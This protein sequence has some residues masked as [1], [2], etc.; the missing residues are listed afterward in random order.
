MSDF[1]YSVQPYAQML[2]Q[3]NQL[4][5]SAAELRYEETQS[6]AAMTEILREAG[7]QVQ[8]GVAGIPTAYR[9]TY[10]TG[11]PVIGL[12]A[13]Y[14]A[15][16]GISQQ[17]D[18]AEYRPRPETTHG[19][20]CGHNLLGVGVIGAALALKDYL[21]DHPNAG[22][23][24]VLGCPAE[25]GGSGKT[26]MAR[27]GVFNDLDI[28]L[29]WH[30]ATINAAMT[31][32]LLANCQ[33]YFSFHGKASHAAA[34]PQKGRSALDA[35]ELMNVGVNY[36]REHMEMTDRVHYAVTNT[37]G[38]S[39]NVVQS[40]AQVL[41]LIRSL[42]NESVKALYERV[43]DIAR[44]A[45]LMTGTSLD[46]T[47]D[48]ACSN[49]VPND[50]LGQ[51]M[52]D[53]MLKVGLPAYTT[54]EGEYIQRFR[55]VIGDE[56]ADN[57]LG[58]LPAFDLD[59]RRSLCQKHPMGDFI[60]PFEPKD[61]VVTA[62]SD[63]GDVSQIVPLIQLQ[64]ACFCLGTPPH[65]WVLAAQGTSSYA[66]KGTLFAA[67]VIA[68]ATATLMESPAMVENAQMENKRRTGAKPYV[69]PIPD[70]I[71]PKVKI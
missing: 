53:I 42:N 1:P 19:H 71:Q 32:S 68:Q 70:N 28:A 15:L 46:I 34:A 14:D 38:I 36:L 54:E 60:L 13:E 16:D 4:I 39:P 55:A 69:C 9:A 29:T 47:F 6:C 40:E 51:L 21:D 66:M 37:G 35:V 7:Y 26:Y 67:Q 17:A 10:G 58:L 33:I 52:Y 63:M 49:V 44:G 2:T 18:V 27:E 62:S 20:G 3:L 11:K 41:Y 8:V 65:S 59:I 24:V 12:L 57:D 56:S 50:T 61:V 22:T 23:V 31:G 25:E 5:W 64:C 48:K 45:A 30:P 43:C